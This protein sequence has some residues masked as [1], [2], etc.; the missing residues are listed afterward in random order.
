VVRSDNSEPP[1]STSPVP[2]DGRPSNNNSV[3]GDSDGD[4]KQ[5]NSSVVFLD[6]TNEDFLGEK[7]RKSKCV[8]P[9]FRPQILK[10]AVH[11][12]KNA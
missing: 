8:S 2:V 5:S 9:F 6:L 10:L 3:N 12:S 11:P 1:D 7:L 4:N